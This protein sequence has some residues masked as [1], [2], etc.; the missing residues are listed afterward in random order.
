MKKF[1]LIGAAVLGLALVLCAGLVF[2]I[3]A[4]PLRGQIQQA[5]EQVFKR[6][7]SAVRIE[8]NRVEQKGEAQPLE[9]GILVAQVVAGSPA[10]KAGV[11]RGDILLE[12]DGEPVNDLAGL[13]A[14]LG[15]HQ[16]GDEVDL[17]V[18]RGDAQRTLTAV[19]TKGKGRGAY[20]GIQPGQAAA[21]DPNEPEMN[22]QFEA[23]AQVTEV[24]ERS[25][26]EDAGLKVGDTILSVDGE[27]FSE[28]KQLADIIAGHKP[29]D[30][31]TFEVKGTDGEAREV[32]VRLSEN[33]DKAG[34]AWL[35]IRYQMAMSREMERMMP[36]HPALPEGE[37]QI[38]GDI[39]PFDNGIPFPPGM[40]AN[41]ALIQD[42][43]K[44]SPA[45]KAGLEA[46]QFLQAVDGQTL[47]S[48][49]DLSGVIA[50]LKP[51]DTVTL[52]VFDP[53]SGDTRDIEI[54]LGENPD[55]AGA[56][57]LGIQYTFMKINFEQEPLPKG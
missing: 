23:G 57:W 2:A 39:M 56:A 13:Q 34:A 16:S 12:V 17:L 20:L 30:S 52:Q 1:I 25:P 49:E 26:A 55:K 41:G 9:E 37:D 50:D 28:D 7:P 21:G 10:D 38:P 48:P 54:T 22:F 31:V 40:M 43:V 27:T 18:Q 6:E 11:Q 36:D 44:D 29:G 45:E 51:G 15:V 53:R 19:L 8:P 42:V 3:V 24:I 4:T 33:P 47:Q 14:V 46:G 35:G 32:T 5:I